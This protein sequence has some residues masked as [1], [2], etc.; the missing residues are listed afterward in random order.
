M[1]LKDITTDCT[2]CG[3]TGSHTG[4]VEAPG[5]PVP[6]DNPCAKCG[7]T[8]HLPHGHLSDDFEDFLNDLKDKVDDIK[9][10]VD[11]IK[12]VVDAL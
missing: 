1:G 8:G 6:F 10:V 9:E 4:V 3:G 2:G 5:G 12:D 11:E 7:G